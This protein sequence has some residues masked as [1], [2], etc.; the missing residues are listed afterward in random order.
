M[1]YKIDKDVPRPKSGSGR[2][3]MYPW[4]KMEVGDSI[5]FEKEK[6]KSAAESAHAY[7]RKRG[8]V[9]QSKAVEGGVRV[10]RIA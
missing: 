9:Y 4:D 1:E 10:W 2:R 8:Q 5:L 6:G 7:G 3:L